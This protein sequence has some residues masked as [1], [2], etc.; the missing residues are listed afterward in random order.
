MRSRFLTEQDLE[1]FTRNGARVRGGVVL[2]PFMGSGSTLIAAKQAGRSAI[3]IELQ[4]IY[5]EIAVKR[6]AQWV[7][8]L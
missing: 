8:A 2:D 7:L 5:C 3:G 1:R 4:E 6:L